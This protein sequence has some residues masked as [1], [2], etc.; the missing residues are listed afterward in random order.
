MI[1]L[2]VVY[3]KGLEV[4]LPDERVAV[5]LCLDFGAKVENYKGRG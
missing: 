3:S 2:P 1:V 4:G 5:G